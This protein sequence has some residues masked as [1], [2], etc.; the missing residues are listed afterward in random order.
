VA[1]GG[2]GR[3]IRWKWVISVARYMEKEERS[4]SEERVQMSIC[5]II[6]VTT[7]KVSSIFQ[8][9]FRENSDPLDWILQKEEAKY[10]K[11]KEAKYC[12]MFRHK[13]SQ[14]FVKFLSVQNFIKISSL[15]IISLLITIKSASKI[16]IYSGNLAIY[17]GNVGLQNFR[18]TIIIYRIS[19]IFFP[20]W[21]ICECACPV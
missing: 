20:W 5:A 2:R 3:D 9:K 15:A 16:N 8:R 11:T 13:F 19:A 21:R 4:R 18:S 12:R 6:S 10:C 17:S 7:P 1:G 14:N